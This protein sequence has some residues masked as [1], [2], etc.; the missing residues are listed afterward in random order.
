MSFF[1]IV[2]KECNGTFYVYR[3]CADC[4]DYLYSETPTIMTPF[5]MRNV[6]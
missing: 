2:I 6:S 3:D 4:M 1:S 5:G